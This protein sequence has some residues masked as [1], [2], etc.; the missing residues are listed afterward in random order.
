MADGSLDSYVSNKNQGGINSLDLGTI[1]PRSLA[2]A[3]DCIVQLGM[4][5]LYSTQVLV[6]QV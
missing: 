5:P 3:R 6:P 4:W 2:M 1:R